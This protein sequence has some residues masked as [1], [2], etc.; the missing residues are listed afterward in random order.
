VEAART[1][2]P[3]D[4][5]AG[6]AALARLVTAV[7]R[8]ESLNPTVAQAMLFN[9]DMCSPMTQSMCT[10]L[11]D[12]ADL[13][14]IEP[15]LAPVT[16]MLLNSVVVAYT[17]AHNLSRQG[18]ISLDLPILSSIN[19]KS[20]FKYNATVNQKLSVMTSISGKDFLADPDSDRY[21]A[22]CWSIYDDP[23]PRS[24]THPLFVQRYA[25][26]VFYYGAK[27]NE[28]EVIR[29]RFE[30]ARNEDWFSREARYNQEGFLTALVA[31]KRGY[32]GW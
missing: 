32:V 18:H 26:A 22:A 13:L 17:E 27:A 15:S 1:A 10:P 31:G 8:D 23:H 16:C 21:K 20:G 5:A 19:K 25:M 29:D 2:N 24:A 7:L 11:V 4:P 6:F 12:A 9:M 14:L 28:D 3:D 30:N